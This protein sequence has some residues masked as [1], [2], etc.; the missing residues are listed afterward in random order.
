ML[1]HTMQRARNRGLTNVSAT[2]GDAQNLP[3]PTA[4]RARGERAGLRFQR[5]VGRLLGHYT[6]LDDDSEG[7]SG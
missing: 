6:V 1:D 7:R 5:R 2:Q 4:L 3:A